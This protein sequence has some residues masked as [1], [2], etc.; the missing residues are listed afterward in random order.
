MTAG[1]NAGAW[2]HSRHIWWQN[3]STDRMP[4]LVD[5]RSFNELLANGRAARE[6]ARR[7]HCA[8]SACGRVF[9]SNKSRP[10]RW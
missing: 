5:R 10:S 2:V 3:E 9:K 8:P 7:M 1:T 4:D 6:V